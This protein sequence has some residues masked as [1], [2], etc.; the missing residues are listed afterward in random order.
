MSISIYYTATR[1]QPLSPTERERVDAVVARRSDAFPVE[2]AET[3][4]L[5]APDPAQPQ[6]VLCGATKLPLDPDD[7]AAALLY[8]CDTLTELR[9][10]AAGA[11][12][13]VAMDD[14]EMAWSP[15]TGFTPS[16]GETTDELRLALG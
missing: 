11:T 4:T 8:W 12:W 2:D 1:E 3:F 15:E 5:Y 9:A 14:L 13:S 6:E 7:S 10:E 16:E